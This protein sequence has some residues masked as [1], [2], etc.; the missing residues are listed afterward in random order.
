[1]AVAVSRWKFWQVSLLEAQAECS[2]LVGGGVTLNELIMKFTAICG[3]VLP[4][5]LT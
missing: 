2:G 1:M 4:N 5:F 3:I